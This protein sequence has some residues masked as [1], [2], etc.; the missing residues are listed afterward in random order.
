MLGATFLYFRPVRRRRRGAAVRKKVDICPEN[1]SK[2]QNQAT[3]K[4][5]EPFSETPLR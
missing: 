3:D 1:Q 5:T 4:T 2:N